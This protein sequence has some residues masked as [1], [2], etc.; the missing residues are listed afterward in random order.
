MSGL[1]S[2]Q[3]GL[4]AERLVERHQVVLEGE[5]RGLGAVSKAELAEDAGHVTFDRLL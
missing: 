3:I 2:A 4:R 5:G 1:G